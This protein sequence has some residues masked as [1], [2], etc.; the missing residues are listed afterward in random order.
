MDQKIDE[1]IE[2]KR[3]TR[4]KL[5]EGLKYNKFKK[6]VLLTGAGISVSAGIPDFRS[7]KVGLYDNLE[8]FKLPYPQAIFDVEFF[9]KTPEPFYRLAKDFLSH[10]KYQPTLTHMFVKLLQNKGLLQINMTQNIDGLENKAGISPDKL[11]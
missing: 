4:E 1:I 8:E 9:K 10:E 5:I 2:K 6:I 7:P 3:F 11:Y